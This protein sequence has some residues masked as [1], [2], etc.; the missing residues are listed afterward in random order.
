MH[1]VF[2]N[3]EILVDLPPSLYHAVTKLQ[4]ARIEEGIATTPDETCELIEAF[5]LHLGRLWLAEFWHALENQQIS[6]QDKN[7]ENLFLL[8]LEKLLNNQLRTIGAWVGLSRQIHGLFVTHNLDTITEGL[9]SFSFGTMG[10]TNHVVAK[11]LQFRNNFAHGTFS[12]PE[13]IIEEQYTLLDQVFSRIPGLWQQP[14]TV[15]IENNPAI[16]WKQQ[17]WI[18]TTSETTFSV[19]LYSASKQQYLNLQPFFTIILDDTENNKEYKV[20]HGNFA[21]MSIEQITQSSIIEQ[22]N[23]QY[24]KEYMGDIERESRI[25]NR[26]KI[27]IDPKLAKEIDT[28]LTNTTSSMALHGYPGTGISGVLSFVLENYQSKFGVFIAWDIVAQDLTQ[29][30]QCLLNKIYRSIAKQIPDAIVENKH[31]TLQDIHNIFSEYQGSVLLAIDGMHHAA[32]HYRNETLS[33]LDV[34]NALIDTDITV[35]MCSHRD[36]LRQGMYYDLRYNWESTEIVDEEDLQ[37]AKTQY[38]TTPF[39]QRLIENL[40]TN[41]SLDLFALC[42]KL[43]T[44]ESMAFEPKVEYGLWDLR[45]LLITHIQNTEIDGNSESTRMWKIFHEKVQS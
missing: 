34:C 14:I 40:S 29:S 19:Y 15:Q 33:V 43:D 16:T 37:H 30:G 6:V 27:P 35:L 26:T 18:N 41:N 4:T 5:F 32:T 38:I 9:G 12:A 24:Q 2:T 20:A 10:D 36:C 7:T 44:E 3:Q 31:Y 8:S 42:D 21:K 1:T 17:Q 23:R 22:W 28:L 39:H 25:A 45:P 11:L 13:N